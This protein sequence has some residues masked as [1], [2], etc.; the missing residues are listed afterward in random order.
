MR[1]MVG[2]LEGIYAPPSSRSVMRIAFR[3]CAPSVSAGYYGATRIRITGT[4]QTHE[5]TQLRAELCSCLKGGR[6]KDFR[7]QPSDRFHWFQAK[8]ESRTSV[9]SHISKICNPLRK[10][11][12][13][14]A[15]A[16]EGVVMRGVLVPESVLDP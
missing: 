4:S 1:P 15:R 9:C 16:G 14:I 5:N 7:R 3:Q 6:W 13:S 12:T 10:V 11:A 2:S 8:E